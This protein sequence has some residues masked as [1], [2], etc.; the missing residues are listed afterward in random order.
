L[1]N[2]S[3]VFLNFTVNKPTNWTGYSLDGDENATVTGNTTLTGLSAGM[4]NVTVYARDEFNN[5]GASETINFS[6]AEEP[7]PFLIVPV[8]TASAAAIAVVGVGLLVY[9]R[10]RKR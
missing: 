8:A 10:R 1:Y 3:S 2:E 4:H 7:A 9:Y 5:T 6:I